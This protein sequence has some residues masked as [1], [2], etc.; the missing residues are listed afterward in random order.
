VTFINVYKKK[1][2][3]G[4]RQ[5]KKGP[6]I[7]IKKNGNYSLISVISLFTITILFLDYLQ[8]NIIKLE[9]WYLLS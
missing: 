4:L 6:I 9:Q 2:L 3:N 1:L 8:F 5:I 7:K